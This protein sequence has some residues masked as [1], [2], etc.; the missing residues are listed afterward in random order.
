MVAA[1][2]DSRFG[3]V[4]SV[5]GPLC[6]NVQKDPRFTVSV[7]AFVEPD[8]DIDSL[9]HFAPV[10][11]YPLRGLSS[12][13][14]G[15]PRSL[16]GQLLSRQI[17][18]CDLV[19]IHGLWQEHC[20]FAAALAR[21][22]GKPYVISAHGMLDPWALKHKGWK[23]SLY[24]RL[25]E[26]KNL[27]GAA[28]LH[29]LTAAEASDYRKITTYSLV[30]TIP[31]AIDLPL[32]ADPGLFVS[33][34]P[35]VSAKTI[36]LFLSRLH[37]K[38]GLDLLCESWSRIAPHC[39]DAHLVIAGPDSE[40]LRSELEAA[41]ESKGLSES[42][43][44]TGMLAGPMKWSALAAAHLFVLPSRS[45]GLSMAALEAMGME[46]PVLLTEQ[47]HVDRL[48]E[49]ECGWQ[50][51][52]DAKELECA[53]RDFLRSPQRARAMGRNAR[54]LIEDRHSWEV[55]GYR[56]RAFYERLVRAPFPVL[57]SI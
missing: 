51:Q 9:E 10:T 14:A 53:L 6:A 37:H 56:M 35:A 34:Y 15:E 2:L 13:F 12:L 24:L 21:R 52:P 1:N 42:V 44:F 26:R 17:E 45:E 31:N 23:K 30:E 16:T 39:P 57:Q 55:V 4:S 22:L 25:V 8:E 5:L 49:H 38:K 48:L 50:I 40:H 20:A 43:T 27:A 54:C 28:A 36:V 3:G 11:R 19:H 47:C 7:A 18:N 32:A 41:F 29:A 33:K 46:K